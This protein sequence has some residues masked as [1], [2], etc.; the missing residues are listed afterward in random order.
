MD[1]NEDKKKAAFQPPPL[2]PRLPEKPEEGR[3]PS[4]L[5]LPA[6]PAEDVGRVLK[7]ILDRLDAIEKRLAKIEKILA[8][9]QLPP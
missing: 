9:R 3:W 2:T 1:G 7:Q 4:P 8:T 5:P 6:V